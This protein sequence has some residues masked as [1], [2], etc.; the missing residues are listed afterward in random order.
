[1][2]FQG[3]QVLFKSIPGENGVMHETAFLF[4]EQPGLIGC[5]SWHGLLAQCD[6]KTA[7]A[8]MHQC[9]NN[10]LSDISQYQSGPMI[11]IVSPTNVNNA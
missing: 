10:R 5:K 1:M 7:F 11:Q 3:S 6:Y 8:I 4:A 9:E 2:V